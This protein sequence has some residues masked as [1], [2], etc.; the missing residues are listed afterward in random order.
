MNHSGTDR[1]KLD[2][3]VLDDLDSFD[4]S[5]RRSSWSANNGN[6]VEAVGL[7]GYVGVRDSKNDKPHAPVLVFASSAWHV[8]L[9]RAKAGQLD[10]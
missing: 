9:R 10:F 3:P 5:W 7:D 6:C 2:R 1:H 8:F 4:L